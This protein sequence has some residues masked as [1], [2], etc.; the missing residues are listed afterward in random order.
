MYLAEYV[1]TS[2]TVPHL[3]DSV[4]DGLER[5][6]PLGHEQVREPSL[7]G[8]HPPGDLQDPLLVRVGR[9]VVRGGAGGGKVFLVFEF[10]RKGREGGKRQTFSLHFL[11]PRNKKLFGWKREK[12]TKCLFVPWE[13]S[14]STDPLPLSLSRSPRLFLKK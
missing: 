6:E 9:V 2:T 12:G 3:L 13:V 10:T 5:L 14:P 11:F 1:V 7:H 8:R 4:V